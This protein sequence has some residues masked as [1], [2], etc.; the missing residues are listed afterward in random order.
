M[1]QLTPYRGQLKRCRGLIETGV[2]SCL[3]KWFY[4]PQVLLMMY[5]KRQIFTDSAVSLF[6]SSLF[7]MYLNKDVNFMSCFSAACHFVLHF[8]MLFYNFRDRHLHGSLFLDDFLASKKIKHDL[9]NLF[10]KVFIIIVCFNCPHTLISNI[11]SNSKK[12]KWV[13]WEQTTVNSTRIFIGAMR[14]NYAQEQT[15]VLEQYGI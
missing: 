5:M 15:I 12:S 8:H 10:E 7:L 2:F 9:S 14:V 11:L 1:F 13:M 4:Q 6:E 3:I